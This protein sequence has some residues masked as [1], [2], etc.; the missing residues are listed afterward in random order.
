[1]DIVFI[2]ITTYT[3]I[4]SNAEHY[5]ARVARNDHV[6]EGLDEMASMQY[7]ADDV[8]GKELKFFPDKYQAR[9]L[10]EKDNRMVAA[11]PE[12]IRPVTDRQ[13]N[14]MMKS[15]TIRFPSVASILRQA[16]EEFP[17]AYLYCTMQGNRRLFIETYLKM[18][19]KDPKTEELI[20]PK[21]RK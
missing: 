5:Y 13:V 7:L 6:I 4:S 14:S 9:A 16:H 21:H 19:Q 12:T 1:M 15:G 20:H 8:N 18:C 2:N 3:G 17:Y 10:C 11:Y